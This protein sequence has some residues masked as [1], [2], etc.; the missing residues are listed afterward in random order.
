MYL[1]KNWCILFD[2]QILYDQKMTAY[3]KLVT[4]DQKLAL[5]E[6]K[7][8]K[9]YE[10]IVQKDQTKKRALDLQ[11]KRRLNELGKPKRSFNSYMMFVDEQRR[12]NP[13]TAPKDL[14]NKYDALTESQKD[15]Y[16]QKAVA[17]FAQYKCVFRSHVNR[18]FSWIFIHLLN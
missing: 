5:K 10:R 17:A 3:N 18:Q 6:V 16:K 13:G 14:K 11:H 9:Q 15:V 12:Q 2:F 7:I 1:M 4:K 8:K